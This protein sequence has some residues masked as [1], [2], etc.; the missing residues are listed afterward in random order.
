MHPSGSLKKVRVAALIV[1]GLIG[2]RLL[3]SVFFEVGH[4]HYWMHE[5]ELAQLLEEA[6]KVPIEPRLGF[7]MTFVDG[8]LEADAQGDVQVRG[9]D[10]GHLVILVPYEGGLHSQ[11][12]VYVD[13]PAIQ[14]A[15]APGFPH[16]EH[17]DCTRVAE[18]WW[19]YTSTKN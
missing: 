2:L 8:R 6:R 19:G 7:S 14:D 15:H 1:V 18:R 11:G 9:A 4:V 13:D 16:V 5:D 10:S 17:W 3:F 12:Y